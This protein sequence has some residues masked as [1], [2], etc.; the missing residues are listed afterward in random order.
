MWSSALIFLFVCCRFNFCHIH[1]NFFPCCT[2]WGIGRGWGVGGEDVL[3]WKVFPSKVRQHCK[4]GAG[5]VGM[6]Q[7]KVISPTHMEGLRRITNAISCYSSDFGLGCVSQKDMLHIYIILLHVSSW[8]LGFQVFLEG[9]L[10]VT[11]AVKVKILIRRDF[12]FSKRKPHRLL[13]L[14]C[15]SKATW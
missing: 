15:V 1:L 13:I 14:F 8:V 3:Y 4:Q 7:C 6:F 11:A 9:I 5:T 10:P 2:I 12:T